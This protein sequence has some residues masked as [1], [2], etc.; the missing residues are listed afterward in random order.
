MEFTTFVR[1][2]FEV[3]AVEI[4]EDNI[5]EIAPLV[6]DLMKKDDG[7]HFIQV[8]K[9][10]VPNMFR[11]YPGDWLTKM[12]N[13]IRCYARRVFTEQFVEKAR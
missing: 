7:S 9:K 4:T 11:V 1:K 12:D 6:G 3:E 2:P 13:N 5:E 8:N 10:K